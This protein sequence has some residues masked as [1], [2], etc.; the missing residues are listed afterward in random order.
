MKRTEKKEWTKGMFKPFSQWTKEE[1]QD[2]QNRLENSEDDDDDYDSGIMS[3]ELTD[4]D[5]EFQQ[6]I[7]LMLMSDLIINF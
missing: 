5:V 3:T 7:G 4:D 2:Y 6:M 1:I